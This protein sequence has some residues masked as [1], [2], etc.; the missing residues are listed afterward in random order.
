MLKD[1]KGIRITAIFFLGLTV[2]LGV[3]YLIK[4]VFNTLVNLI[5]AASLIVAS[6]FMLNREVRMLFKK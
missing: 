1:L 3:L 6:Y 5:L 4:G 2:I